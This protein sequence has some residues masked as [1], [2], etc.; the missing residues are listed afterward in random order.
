ML[1]VGLL[2]GVIAAMSATGVT[3]GSMSKAESKPCDASFIVELTDDIE[4][5]SADEAIKQQDSVFAKIKRQINSNVVKDRNFTILN[6]AFVVKGN[7]SDK[8]AILGIPGVKEVTE[9]GQHVVKHTEGS[10]GFTISVNSEG[11]KAGGIDLSQN[12]SAITMNKPN[13]TAD[14][15]G[16]FIAVLDNE[17]YL[18]GKHKDEHGADQ[19]AYNHVT[20][21]PLA[22]DVNLRIKSYTLLKNRAENTYVYKKY[23]DYITENKFKG[24]EEGSLY[25]NNKV[26][27]YYDYAGDSFNG[28]SDGGSENF[29]VESTIDLHGSHV[30]S[31]AAGNDPD[32]KGIAPKAQLALMKVF[33]DV[34]ETPASA[35]A[36]N[37]NY[38]T[39][40]EIGFIQALED[41][42]ALK[43]DAINVSI[44]SDLADFEQGSISQRTLDKIAKAGILSSI[45]AGNGG[46]SSYAF[47]GGYANWTQDIVETGV[48]GSFANNASTMTIA[49]GQPVWT[50]YEDSL[51]IETADGAQV[52][53]YQ[54]Q[55]V[56][57]DGEAKDYN[58]EKR[59]VQLVT[60]LDDPDVDPTEAEQLT[61][62]KYVYIKGF[63]DTTDYQGVDVNGKVVIVNRGKIDFS[64]KYQNAAARGAKAL[65]IIN[66][67]P[68]ENDFTFRCDFGDIKKSINKPVALILFK[69]KPFFE[70]HPTGEFMVKK[71]TS[72]ENP[73]AG[74]I[75]DYSTD[76]ATYDL[77]L[78][79][80]ITSPGSNIKGAVWP[81]NKKER[82]H[83]KYS[84]YEYFNG[85]SMAAPNYEGAMAV[86]LSKETKRMLNET[87][88]IDEKALQ[89]FKDTI[90]MRMMSTADPMVDHDKNDE[91][92]KQTLTSPRMQGA[93]MVDLGGAYNTDV[94]IKGSDT[95]NPDEALNTSKIM[96]RN[97]DAIAKGKI[98]LSFTL[99]NEADTARGFD[100]KFNVMRPAKA[101]CNKILTDDYGTPI[102]VSDVRNFTGWEYYAP[103][104]HKL[105]I[106][107]GVANYKDVFKVS[108]DIEYFLSE[109]E[110]LDN[111]P[112]GVIKEGLYYCPV[113]GH[114]EGQK[115]DWKEVPNSDYQSVK[116]VEIAQVNAKSVS[117]PAKSSLKVTLDEYSISEAEK[118]KIEAMYK[119]GTYIEGFVTLTSKD[120]HEDLSVPYMGFY[121]LTDRHADYDY[122]TADVVE[123]FEFEKDPLKIYGSDLINDVAK[124]LVGKDY[125][126]FG[127]LMVAGYAKNP[128]NIN[129]DKIV[130]NDTSFKRLEGFY[131]V[132][133]APSVYDYAYTD[134]PSNDIYL[135]N[136]LKSNTLIVQQFVMRSVKDNYFTIVNKETG[137]EVYRN[138]LTDMLFGTTAGKPTLYKSHVDA[139]Y[140]GGGYIAHRAYSIIPM[141]DP[142][143]KIPFASGEYELKFNYQLAATEKWV[144]K[145]YNL[146]IDAESPVVS[147]ILDVEQDGKQMVRITYKDMRCAY[148][149]VGSN[150]VEVKYDEKEKVY[151]SLVDKSI[152][153]GSISKTATDFSS[154]RLIIRAYDY[155]R[156]ETTA[157]VHFTGEDYS[158]FTIAQGQGLT[159]TC[160][161]TYE[162][163]NLKIVD[164]KSDG[165]KV[166]MTNV[167]GYVYVTGEP[168]TKKDLGLILGLSIG[169]GVLA[170]GGIGVALY[171]LVFKKK[172]I[173]GK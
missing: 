48:M 119:A 79:P 29:D 163:G 23:K 156:G 126:E 21:S 81:Q 107:E 63:G 146:H 11:S 88:K 108:K 169:G 71:N 51:R 65:L 139:D 93:G 16:T 46:K 128:K 4:K 138:A 130:S 171:F 22:D 134:T 1:K 62:V 129:M 110:Y 31:I 155:A 162:N 124:S 125:A 149:L 122:S 67:D 94:Y 101:L 148:A 99:V 154:S 133:T 14:G 13:N 20:F 75:S 102:E 152:V 6:N 136:P 173:G 135:G 96:L 40:S 61:K 56:N 151:Y 76:G 45:S 69:D 57:R 147:S 131:P 117:V 60:G 85:T 36:G 159:T 153:D 91:D 89:K 111:N 53:P 49:A 43:V 84:A 9:D 64:T 52:V 104:E 160:D 95:N 41:C 70:S 15:E 38:A 164:F 39:F 143:T 32:Y 103:E 19:P 7:K 27:F 115:I 112:T 44:G 50:F 73:L 100:V 72:S 12:A 77:D 86:V 114:Q 80:E 33:R 8:E 157:I 34:H 26:P 42:I 142:E 165:T 3:A 150:L 168:E 144:S 87:G 132:G 92:N 5:L 166:E 158:H 18:R 35:D 2:C 97:S 55:I 98:N 109:Q 24:G 118:D 17:F 83:A 78:K 170:L 68:T 106:A 58:R 121:S 167:Y 145:S 105:V 90:N 37:G 116:D 127:S 74:S 66:N 54:D 59:M 30:A 25:F 10:N 113:Q 120:S 28:S 82:E 172:K 161:F 140:L 123:P 141:Y 137:K 47:T